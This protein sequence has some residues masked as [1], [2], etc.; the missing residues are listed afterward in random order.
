MKKF[1]VTMFAM[2]C[3]VAAMAQNGFSAAS[4]EDAKAGST[5]NLEINVA[6]ENEMKAFAFRLE[7]PTGFKA[8][9]VSKIELGCISETCE[10]DE[11]YKIMVDNCADG[12]K[13]YAGIVT[14]GEVFQGNSGVAMIIPVD[15]AATVEEGVYTIKLY[16]GDVGQK[17]DVTKGDADYLTCEIPV[18]V[19][20]KTA[21]NTINAADANAPIYNVAGQQV[22]KAQ[23]GIFIQNGKKILK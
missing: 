23:K 11:L 20:T 15:I 10:E 7:M 13:Q 14:D 6:H 12:N 17:I 8:K 16:K 1:Y 21:I 3:G 9:G 19:G 4:I 2:L 18:G 5:V 22:S